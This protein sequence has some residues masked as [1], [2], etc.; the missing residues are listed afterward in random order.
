MYDIAIVGGG[1][2][3]IAAA[4]NAR[5]RNKNTVVV[6]KENYSSKLVQARQ[7]ENFLGIPMI[8]G[9]ELAKRIREHAESLAANFLKDEIQSIYPEDHQ[10]H[11]IGR[12]NSFQAKTVILAVG[13]SLGAEI[14]GESEWI[15]LGVSYCI[16][17][18]GMFFKNKTVAVIGY[19]PEAE[20]ELHFLA[21][22]CANVYYLP[23]YKLLGE[24]DSRITLL[25]DKPIEITGT[26]QVEK[27]KL[28][29]GELMVDGIFIERSAL[30]I[31]QLLAD[32]KTD[33]GLILC[34]Q[35]QT[36]NL[37]GIFAA[38]DCTGKPWQISRAIGQGQ[39]AALSAV[40][41]LEAFQA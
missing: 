38:G 30:P 21:D 31:T 7:I 34:D 11:L 19:I 1:P 36:T 28:S 29:G 32:L 9:Q 6:S 14:R 24:L 39:V 26:H 17:C 22:I 18:D 16:T 35:N 2:A 4:V 13:V 40:N 8:S 3:G 41:Y 15:G 12:E 33:Q 5:R 37:P 27:L 10:F 20:S 23:Q 25:R